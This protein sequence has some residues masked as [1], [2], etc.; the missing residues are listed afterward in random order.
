MKKFILTLFFA[1]SLFAEGIYYKEDISAKEAYEMQKSGAIVIDVRT[2]HE[3]LYAGHGVGHINVPA[4]YFDIKT[5]ELKQ[6]ENLSKVEIEKN[7]PFDAHKMYDI[8]DIENEKLFDE[9]KTIA[10][11]KLDQPIIF[12]CRTGIRSQYAANIVA[13]KG[14][15]NVYNVKE[16]FLNGWKKENLPWGVE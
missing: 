4:F 8:R 5:K 6:R 13:Q 2:P 3:F 10:K 1:L 15:E 14:F 12:I 7:K 9:V 11:N 16:G